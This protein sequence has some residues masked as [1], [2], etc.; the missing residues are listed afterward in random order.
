MRLKLSHNTRYHYGVP[1]RHAMQVL[2]LTPRAHDGQFVRDWRIAIDAD[3]LLLAGEDALGNITRTFFIEGPVS[4]V[5]VTVSG[6]VDTAD[7]AGRVSGTRETFPPGFWLRSSDLTRADPAI[8]QFAF[9]LRAAEGADS[10]A[11]LHAL[12]RAIQAQM[13]FVLGETSMMTSAAE[14]WANHSG[15]C[16]DFAQVFLSAAHVL[17]IPARYVSG[18][19]LLHETTEQT[20]G[21]AWAEAYIEGLGWIG[22]DPANGVCVDERYVRVAIGTNAHD[23]APVRGSRAGGGTETLDVAVHVSQIIATS[24]Q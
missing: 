3:G 20:A 14:A 17:D 16:Q 12:M 23:A 4:E 18:Y 2:R 19:Y 1:V 15:V 11:T 13:R 22:F 5:N 24:A 21:H 10:V 9:G 8:A 7:T 6:I